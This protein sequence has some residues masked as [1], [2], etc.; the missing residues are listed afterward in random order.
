MNTYSGIPWY[1]P[2][3]RWKAPGAPPAPSEGPRPARSSAARCVPQIL[4]C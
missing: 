2:T 3:A 1:S 4:V